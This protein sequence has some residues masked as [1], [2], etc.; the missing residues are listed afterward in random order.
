MGYGPAWKC[1]NGILQGCPISVMMLNILMSVSRARIDGI[2]GSS[3][4]IL[5]AV[6]PQGYADDCCVA[7]TTPQALKQAIDE[8][9][10]FANKTGLL[11]AGEKCHLFVNAFADRAH[12][13]DI[14]ASG[15][16]LCRKQ[17]Q[18]FG[19]FNFR[20]CECQKWQRP[21]TH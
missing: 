4:N 10:N 17:F 6:E 7:A 16:T 5:R 11:L 9:K 19:R 18:Q 2:N 1:T 15:N 8:S 3:R 20:G 13:E 14:S 12:L 21:K